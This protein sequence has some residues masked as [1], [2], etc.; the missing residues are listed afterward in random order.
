M[1]AKHL[2]FKDMKYKDKKVLRIAFG[3]K[4]PPCLM[5][6]W[7]RFMPLNS[8]RM[9]RRDGQTKFIYTVK[10]AGKVGFCSRQRF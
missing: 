1:N 4:E 10:L 5:Y 9:I 7:A 3:P 6:L 2:Y 8:I